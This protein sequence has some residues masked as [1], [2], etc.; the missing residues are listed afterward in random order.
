M[1][2]I[3]FE[4]LFKF[5]ITHNLALNKLLMCKIKY[6]HGVNCGQDDRE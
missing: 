4:N 2:F 5:Y 1:S 3:E 6:I